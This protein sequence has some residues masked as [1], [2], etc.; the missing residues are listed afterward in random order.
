MRVQPRMTLEQSILFIGGSSSDLVRSLGA[1]LCSNRSLASAKALTCIAKNHF[2]SV[3]GDPD[4]F[5]V[6]LGQACAR[7]CVWP[8]VLGSPRE[9]TGK[10]ACG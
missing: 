3:I 4:V 5:R 9:G 6:R 7:E 1:D 8:E 10:E 2:P